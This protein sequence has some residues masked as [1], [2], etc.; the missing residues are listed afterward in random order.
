MKNSLDSFH[1]VILPEPIGVYPLAEGWYMLAALLFTFVLYFGIKLLRL[2]LASRY[3]REALKE[4]KEIQNLENNSIKYKK[5][6]QLLRRTAIITYGREAVSTLDG[7]NWWDFLNQKKQFF[8]KEH[9]L[10]ATTLL[11]QEQ[12]PSED[13]INSF[14]KACKKWIKKHD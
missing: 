1:D 5:L 11:Y 8:Q 3:K 12:E 7:D 14:A 6:L 2:F 10:V 9:Q 4:L 13:D